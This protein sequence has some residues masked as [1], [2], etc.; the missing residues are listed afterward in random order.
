LKIL[1]TS[2]WHIDRTFQQ[3]QTLE[4]ARQVIGAMPELINKHGIDVVVADSC[5]AGSAG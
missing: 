4:A 2:D 3:Y 1:H 5:D